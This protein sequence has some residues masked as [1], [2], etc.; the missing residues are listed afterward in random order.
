MLKVSK[1]I[2]RYVPP[3]K[4][5]VMVRSLVSYGIALFMGLIT[6]IQMHWTA[7]PLK[8]DA[9][10]GFVCLPTQETWQDFV[11]FYLFFLPLF[12]AIPMGYVAY[13]F[14]DVIFKSKLLPKC[15]GRRE[16]AIYFFRISF[17][18][19]FFWTPT[20]TLCFVLPGLISPWTR[21]VFGTISHYQG[22]ASALVSLFKSDVKEAFLNFVFCRVRQANMDY[23][24]GQR[25]LKTGVH[26]SKIKGLLN[27][28]PF[29]KG[30]ISSNISKDEQSSKLSAPTQHD[31]KG[32]QQLS[33]ASTPSLFEMQPD[34]PEYPYDIPRQRDDYLFEDE[35]E[36]MS[37]ASTLN[38][39][40][41]SASFVLDTSGRAAGEKR[42]AQDAEVCQ[43]E[44]GESVA[45]L[46]ATTVANAALMTGE[47]SGD[48]KRKEEVKQEE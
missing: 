21:F 23:T 6:L 48:N 40:G 43:A 32:N 41:E 7:F 15:G 20:V 24:E 34:E 16:I 3:T 17:V 11:F 28:S 39:A 46:D 22:L 19:L 1:D 38:Y 8:L 2:K 12:V 25:L 33:S 26:R 37:K 13:V 18:F 9:N 30:D 45:C 29:R 47:R 31:A 14:Y 4:R 10:W 27:S 42:S 35:I 36:N 44:E 5:S